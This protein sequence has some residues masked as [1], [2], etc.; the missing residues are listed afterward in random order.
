MPS[1]YSQPFLA[2]AVC[3]KCGVDHSQYVDIWEVF[4]N[5]CVMSGWSYDLKLCPNC[6]VR[7]EPKP[8]LRPMPAWFDDLAVEFRKR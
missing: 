4:V 6:N 2:H 5:H 3:Q 8:K 7:I 1:Y